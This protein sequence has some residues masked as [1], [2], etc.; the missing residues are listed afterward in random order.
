MRQPR[1][2]HSVRD[3]YDPTRAAVMAGLAELDNVARRKAERVRAP[4][5]ARGN[6]SMNR[7]RGNQVCFHDMAR[8]HR[9]GRDSKLNRRHMQA[10]RR[11]KNSKPRALGST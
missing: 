6:R 7:E 1:L 3:P 8:A 11:S 10:H 2:T 4:R 5:C 9:S